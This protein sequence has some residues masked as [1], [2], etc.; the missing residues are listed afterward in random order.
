MEWPIEGGGW[1]SGFQ[2]KKKNYYQIEWRYEGKIVK[3]VLCTG[4][5]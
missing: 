2:A 5:V 3:Q 4:V 1:I